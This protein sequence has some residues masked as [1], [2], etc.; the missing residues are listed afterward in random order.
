MS[1]QNTDENADDAFV[2]E[3][4]RTTHYIS[5]KTLP[6]SD[7]E[8]VWILIRNYILNLP[9]GFF[10][11]AITLLL[12]II[13]QFCFEYTLSSLFSSLLDMLLKPLSGAFR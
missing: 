13:E 10:I 12:F 8:A 6:T 2:S 3:L 4:R 9:G 1:Q 7:A 5:A 11:A